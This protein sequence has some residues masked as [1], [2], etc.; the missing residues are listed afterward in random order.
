FAALV[1]GGDFGHPRFAGLEDRWP[2]IET[3]LTAAGVATED[4]VLAWDFVTASDAFLRSDLTTMRDAALPA[5]GDAGANLSFVVTNTLPNLPGRTHKRYL[6]TFAS[7]DFLTAGEADASVLRRG[8]DG[9]PAMDGLRDARF[10]AIIPSCIADTERFPLPRPTVVF[11][12][13]LFGSSEEYA[14]DGF[15]IDL[16]NDF[17]F[18]VVAGDFIGLS[19]R[20]LPVVALAINDM[21]RGPQISEKLA[22]AVIDFIALESAARGPMASDPA[23]QVEGEPVIDPTQVHYLGGSLGGIMGNTILAYDPNFTKGVLAVPGGV[24]SMLF[25][26]S[27]AWSA[28]LGTAQGSYTDAALYQ[29]VVAFL[30]MAM[31][32]YDPITTAAHVTKDPLFGQPAK[33]VLIWYTLGDSLVTNITTEMVVRE[34]GIPVLAPTV[35]EPWNTPVEEGPLQSGVTVYD[36]HPD[37]MPPETNVPPHDDNGT[38]SGVN[39]NGAVLRQVEQ[40]LLFDQIIATCKQGDEI[41]A[42]D[43]NPDGGGVCD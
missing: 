26:R 16:A 41:V 8:P 17:C 28:L 31:E 11:G 36:E 10:S 21:N 24:W 33:E 13:G 23:F 40:F 42:C 25:E 20:Q 3:A 15:V 35:R 39:R 37:P 22:Q 19:S 1:E 14:S 6:G 18:V 32:P 38:H 9:L 5:I 29:L 43:C 27:A 2:A 34:M 12:H 4:L 7:P 30:G